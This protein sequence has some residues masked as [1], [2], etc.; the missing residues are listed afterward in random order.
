MSAVSEGDGSLA[1]AMPPDLMA[2]SG[3]KTR[4]LAG[5]LVLATPLVLR[6]VLR[7]IEIWDG[8]ALNST[9]SVALYKETEVAL[10]T[11]GIALDWGGWGYESLPKARIEE[12]PRRVPTARHEAAFH[13][14]R[15]PPRPS[16]SDVEGLRI[17]AALS[18]RDPTEI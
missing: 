14:R 5:V 17:V 9:P 15:L 4:V 12:D 1:A 2:S 7:A 11:A 13:A 8:V 16:R 6:V 3:Q 18:G 10:C